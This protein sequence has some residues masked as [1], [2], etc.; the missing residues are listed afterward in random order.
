MKRTLAFLALCL[1][2]VS[3]MGTTVM[4]HSCVDKDRD[5]WCD[6]CGMLIRHTCVDANKDTWCDKCSCWIP[7]TCADRDADHLCDQCGKVMDVNI[8]ITVTGYLS[9]KYNTTTVYF[10]EG[11]YPNTFRILSGSPASHTFSCA[12]NSFFRLEVMKTGHPTR[13][14]FHNTKNSNIDIY[15][16]LFPYGDATQDGNVNM[17]DISMLY[18]HIR[19]TALITDD[20][21]LACADTTGDREI[22]M[23]DISRL[24][25]H[26]RGTQK[27][28]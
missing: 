23:G 12:A 10:Y 11:T 26:I 4:A 3:M 13:S 24:Y 22:N 14:Y 20:Y 17:G 2:L 21:A 5:Y 9:E 25:A 28:Y 8:N 16:E 1:L 27:L 15:A 19:Q 6:D 18:A 7:H